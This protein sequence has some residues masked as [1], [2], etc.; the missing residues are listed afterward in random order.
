M[1]CITAPKNIWEIRG[2]L[3]KIDIFP[4]MSLYFHIS[5]LKILALPLYEIYVFGMS[6]TWKEIYMFA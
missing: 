2:A 6:K 1:K 3:G 5:P 4:T